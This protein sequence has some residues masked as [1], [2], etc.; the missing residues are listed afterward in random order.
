MWGLAHGPWRRNLKASR[1]R[2]HKGTLWG[3]VEPPQ[4]NRN[5]MASTHFEDVD[6]NGEEAAGEP[7]TVTVSFE[8]HGLSQHQL[9]VV[10]GKGDDY[11][12]GNMQGKRALI[13]Y[14]V[15]SA[16][17]Q[18]VWI[19]FSPIKD[20]TIK[21]FNLGDD[22]VLVDFAS[23]VYMVVYLVSFLGSTWFLEKH[24]VRRSIFFAATLNC[25]GTLIRYLGSLGPSFGVVLLGQTLCA[26]TQSFTF[27]MPSY[28]SRAWFPSN[29]VSSIVGIAWSFVYLGMALGLLVPPIWLGN[30]SPA[31]IPGLMF[32]FFVSALA[33]LVS[34]FIFYPKNEPL[35]MSRLRT[36][37]SK[38][39]KQSLKETMLATVKN[40]EFLCVII[41]FGIMVGAGYAHSTDLQ[42]IYGHMAS[43]EAVGFLGFVQTICGVVGVFIGGRLVNRFPA[44]KQHVC[45][46]LYSIAAISLGVT[47]ACVGSQNFGGA[48]VFSCIFFFACISL[49]ATALEYAIAINENHGLSPF[50]TS[51]VMMASVQFFG[52]LLTLWLGLILDGVDELNRTMALARVNGGLTV[53]CVFVV[54]GWLLLLY[55]VFGTFLINGR[56]TA[57]VGG[58]AKFS[59]LSEYDTPL[60]SDM[61][62][63]QQPLD[64]FTDEEILN[65]MDFEH[66]VETDEI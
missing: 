41:W 16:H 12:V 2:Q 36:S 21:F 1:H 32:A 3:A 42:S 38:E 22:I 45:V 48:V 58:S 62:G 6:L 46:C 24:G 54:L 30:L 5:R 53:L 18:M 27:G 19:C 64:R 23:T 8:E 43:D 47:S 66:R 4:T 34:V 13:L 17:N 26:V 33:I 9:D 60:T 52:I 7:A 31:P 39:E 15:L 50:A 10:S 40:T 28:L 11:D 63:N 14:A 57:G 59:V 44:Y 29:V 56:S 37:S 49:N 51:A 25:A 55:R 35:E 65:T 61:H 20:K